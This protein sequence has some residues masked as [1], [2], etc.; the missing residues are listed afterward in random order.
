MARNLRLLSSSGWT[1]STSG[2]GTVRRAGAEPVAMTEWLRFSVR[3]FDALPPRR[4]TSA[5]PVPASEVEVPF[6]LMIGW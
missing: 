5:L 2:R 1:Y 4:S 6:T 3:V